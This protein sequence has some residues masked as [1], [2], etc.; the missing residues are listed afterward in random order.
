MSR[1][2]LNDLAAFAA[3]ANHQS[4][5][6]AADIMG[7]S[8][9]ALSHAIIGLEGKVGIRLFNRT[10]RSVSLTQAGARLLARLDPV[11]QDLDQALDT[12]SEER[13]TPSGSLRINANKSGARILLTHVVP[14]F[15]DLYPDVELDL[16]SEGRLIDIVEQGF[17][18]G[19][20]LLEAVPKDMVAVKFGGDVR[21][22][23]VAAPSYLEGRAR[24]HTPDDLLAHRCIRQRL[25]SGKRYRWE[26]SKRGAE[27]AIDVPGNLT[28]DD[29]DLLVQAAVDGR[30][31]A[32]VPD[33]FAQPFLA[34]G[35][36]VT[37]LDDWCPPTPGLALYY[38]RS[39]HVPS[40]LRAFIDLL[41]EVDKSR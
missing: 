1:P 40:P 27:V 19:I 10:T 17:D 11:L 7:V 15:L 16:V 34:S 8:R 6:K 14:R 32:Y 39:R 24:P 35:Q 2:S 5:R 13:G 41:R 3:V 28:L 21:F 18:A 36:L 38:P 23:A 26:F 4:F 9:S 20:R 22:I 31:I 33:Y 30:G 37:V 12:I 25:P 29:N